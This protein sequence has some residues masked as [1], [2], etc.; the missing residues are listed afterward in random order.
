[1]RLKR[2]QSSS[3]PDTEEGSVSSLH[4]TPLEFPSTRL[5]L[6]TKLSLRRC[7]GSQQ[8]ACGCLVGLY[9]RFTGDVLPVVDVACPQHQ[10]SLGDPSPRLGQPRS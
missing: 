1:M 4:A 2:V 5:S 7:V 8:L 3:V 6:L 10:A 9:E